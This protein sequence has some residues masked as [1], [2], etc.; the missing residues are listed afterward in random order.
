MNPERTGG[1]LILTAVDLEAAAL[2]RSLELPLLRTLPFRAYG[3]DGLRLAAVGLGADLLA[4]RWPALLAGLASPLVVSAGVCGGL[5]P[6]LPRGALVVP[7]RVLGPT[8]ACFDL[9][10]SP[11]RAR[12]AAG[13]SARGGA[14]VTAAGVAATAADKAALRARTGAVAVD[15]ESAHVVAAA[16][17][18]GCPWL[19]VRGVSDGAGEAVP[20]ELSGLIGAEG[21]LR[22]AGAVAL[23]LTRPGALGRAIAL[24]RGSRRALAAVSGALAALVA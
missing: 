14:L 2:A 17:A 18:A 19:V 5:D 23:V 13:G 16:E 22:V 15:L 6:A 7:E 4:R 3:R 12:V 21:R 24:G 20:P 9:G 11:A 8:G 10:P 1:T